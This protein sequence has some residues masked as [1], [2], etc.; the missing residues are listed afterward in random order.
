MKYRCRL[1]AEPTPAR[2]RSNIRRFGTSCA[3]SNSMPLRSIRADRAEHAARLPGDEL[4]ADPIASMTHAITIQR[5]PHDV[6]PWLAQMGAGTRGGWYSYDWLDNN[7]QPSADRIRPNLRD[8]GVGTLFPAMPGVTDGFHVLVC[9]PVQSLVIGWRPAPRTSPI[10]TWAFVLRS[11]PGNRTRLIVR[12]RGS[13]DYPFYGLPRF[14][15]QPLIRFAHFVME[16]KQLHGI[17]M[18]VESQSTA[19]RGK[20]REVA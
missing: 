3:S 9:D 1:C 17:A 10:M 11:L 19:S 20:K 18:R 4:I 8:I 13:H 15:G 5:G 16:R 6:W 2:V 12:A 14:I 7:G